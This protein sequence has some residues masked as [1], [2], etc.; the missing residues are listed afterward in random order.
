VGGGAYRLYPTVAADAFG[1]V[2]RALDLTQGPPGSGPGQIL[3]GS[4]W[5]FQYWHRNAAAGGAGFN[6]SDAFAATFTP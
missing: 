4:T 6:L 3:A 1:F 2:S 5:S